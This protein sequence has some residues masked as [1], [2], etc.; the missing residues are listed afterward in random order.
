MQC[1]AHLLRCCHSV[2][3]FILPHIVRYGVHAVPVIYHHTPTLTTA[4]RGGVG[5]EINLQN[6]CT[7]GNVK[8]T[9]RVIHTSM[10][11]AYIR[12]S[13]ILLIN[14]T[15]FQ[16]II[17]IIYVGVITSITANVVMMCCLLLC[18]RITL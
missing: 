14:I 13:S 16:F 11:M 6:G 9:Y 18:T 8:V 15:T 7:I 2:L 3:Q 1:T 17:N 5:Q 10:C 4:L 12:I